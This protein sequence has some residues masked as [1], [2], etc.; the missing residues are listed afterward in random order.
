[1]IDFYLDYVP[2]GHLTDGTGRRVPGPLDRLALNAH[3]RD[4]R[5]VFVHEPSGRP[6]TATVY[7]ARGSRRT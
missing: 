4:P 3:K 2:E 1:M 5:A 6:G 7:G